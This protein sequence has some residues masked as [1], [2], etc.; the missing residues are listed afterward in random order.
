VEFLGCLPIGLCFNLFFGF[1]LSCVG[2]WLGMQQR[3][4]GFYAA[5]GCGPCLMWQ[6]VQDFV[7][8]SFFWYTDKEKKVTASHGGF[9]AWTF[10]GLSVEVMGLGK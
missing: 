1:R 3:V 5:C 10:G 4:V 6:V 2:C 8:K 7:K 9:S